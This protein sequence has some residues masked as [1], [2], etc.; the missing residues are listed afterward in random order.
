[1]ASALF[2]LMLAG[3]SVEPMQTTLPPVPPEATT[4]ETDTAA[5]RRLRAEG[6][7]AYRTGDLKTAAARLA[8]ADGHLPNHPGVMRLRARV[9]AADGDP[10]ESLAQLD[11][12]ARA[13]LTLDV[14]AEPALTERPE[15]PRQAA[16]LARLLE[17]AAAVGA[18]RLSVVATI[19]GG[20]LVES[21]VRD[22]SGERWLVSRVAGRDIL[23]VSDDG[24]I[25]DFLPAS[26]GTEGVL[27]L[28]LDVRAGLIW[29]ATSPAP[30]AAHGRD[31]TGPAAI[32]AIDL[33]SG[34]VRSVHP[35]PPSGASRGI[36]DLV[37]T[38][39]GLVY[40][41]DG[42][43]GEVF[44]LNPASGTPETFVASGV[45]ASPQGLV[46]SPDGQALIIADYSSGLW[47]V[48]RT[49]EPPHRMTTPDDA[50]LIGVDGL[51][52]DGAALY[53][54]QNGVTP[55]R[56]LRLVPDADWR[57][58]ETVDVLAANLPELDEPTTGVILGRDLVF[59]ARSQ[60]SDFDSDGKLKTS[61]PAA[62]VVARLRL[63]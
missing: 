22:V 43:T 49:G 36:G 3:F 30:P 2:A 60:W 31:E 6:V 34:E 44:R 54:L 39:D 29:A 21:V 15:T 48:P 18:D 20:G 10:I 40:V 1:M 11:R 19:P 51:I 38:R 59:I 7:A 14:A 17:N 42:L 41:S 50:V 47:F 53:A 16:V 56:I 25:T 23:A 8:E 55:Q 45:L 52:T 5:F 62:A 46:E 27:G 12:Y 24:R 61:E 28:A 33:D 13:G 26:K 32:L 9:A 35:L 63:D 57:R 37:R 4:R 58:I